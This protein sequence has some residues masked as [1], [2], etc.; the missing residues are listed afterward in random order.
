MN[1]DPETLP[2]AAA[3]SKE[4]YKG[5]NDNHHVAVQVEASLP[6]IGEEPP[7]H[8]NDYNDTNENYSN[9][10]LCY[11]VW[12]GLFS[13]PA[14]PRGAWIAVFTTALMAL[15]LVDAATDVCGFIQGTV[16]LT[17]TASNHSIPTTT[18]VERRHIGLNQYEDANGECTSWRKG[19]NKDDVYASN[20]ILW[21]VVRYFVG[22]AAV[23]GL[24]GLII[25][26]AASCFAWSAT[27]LQALSH[28]MQAVWFLFSLSFL[29][30]ATK[31][32]EASAWDERPVLAE[33]FED[34]TL[35][36]GA[37]LMLA[38]VVLWMPASLGVWYLAYRCQRDSL[39][40]AVDREQQD[41][42]QPEEAGTPTPFN[43]TYV[44]PW[45]N[46]WVIL[47]VASVAINVGV[48]ANRDNFS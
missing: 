7:R 22:V 29:V 21:T 19:T 14:V 45:V 39:R 1:Q 27:S 34:C 47:V 11:S 20:D 31:T 24:I 18:R 38:G 43:M 41:Y 37:G 42:T 28:I 30:L 48:I 44:K 15:I 40:Q 26:L 2:P 16:Y 6:S 46:V 33:T 10:C 9:V 3:V 4:E 25:L 17:T 35:D 13:F 5:N 8:D 12:H 23:V 36:V 32:C